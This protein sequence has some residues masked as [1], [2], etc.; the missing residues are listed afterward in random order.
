VRLGG[1]ARVQGKAA[2]LTRIAVERARFAGQRLQRDDLAPRLRAGGDGFGAGIVPR[3]R[4]AGYARQGRLF[5]VLCDRFGGIA[6]R[7]GDARQPR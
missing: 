2:D 3:C 6:E 5:Q 1:N 4:T 7:L